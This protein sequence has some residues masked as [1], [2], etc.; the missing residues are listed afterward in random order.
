MDRLR[1]IAGMGKAKFPAAA[2]REEKDESVVFF[3]ELYKREKNR[4]TD[5]LEP[6]YSVESSSMPSK[7]KYLAVAIIFPTHVD[8]ICST[9]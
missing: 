5:L 3:R 8:C 9:D 2:A 4:D 6:M 7:V 1:R